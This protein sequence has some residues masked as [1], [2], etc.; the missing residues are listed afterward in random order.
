[1]ASKVNYSDSG[2]LF[3]KDTDSMDSEIDQK[4]EKEALKN[5][6]VEKNKRGQW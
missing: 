1:M 5:K 6:S 3:E 4:I 2:P